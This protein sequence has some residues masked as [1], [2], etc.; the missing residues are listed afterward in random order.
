MATTTHSAPRFARAQR[1]LLA[2]AVALATS[3]ASCGGGGGGGGARLLSIA[4]TP[5]NPSIAAGTT[6]QFTATGTYSNASTK[7]LTALATWSSSDASMADVSNAAGSAGLASGLAAGSPTI[8]A[9][10]GGITGST[11]LTVSSASL[12][13]IEVTPPNPSI[14][15]GTHVRFTATGVFSDGTTQNLTTQVVWQA[16]D[17]SLA[18]FSGVAGEEGLADGVGVGAPGVTATLSGVVGSTTLSVTSAVLAAI[19]VTPIDPSIAL[20]TDLQFTATGV[21]S[22]GTTQDLT[23]L[24]DWTS[25]TGAVSVSSA[26]PANGHAHAAAVGSSTITATVSGI[27]GS[28]V[29]GVTP[30]ALV[31]IAVSPTDSS[32]ALGTHQAMTAMG[33]FTDATVQ[34]LTNQV[35]WSSSDETAV[36]VSNADGSRGIA[37][38]VARGNATI[39][40]T[41]GAV[42]GSTPMT[43]TSATLVSIDVTPAEPTIA[44]GRTQAFQATGTFTDGSTQDLTDVVTWSSSGAAVALVSNADGS[45]GL[46]ASAGAGVTTIGAALGGVSGS[47]GLTV[48]NAVLVSIETSPDA[49]DL[50][51]GFTQAFEAVGIFSDASREDLTGQVTWSSSDETIAKVSNAAGTRGVATGIGAG[52]ATITAALG[53]TS[54]SV[55]LNVTTA[56][57][58]SIDVSP[59]APTLAKGTELPLV[60][61]GTY[62]DDS[63][64]DL[65]DVVAW[66][67]S[68]E[69]A[70]IVSNAPGNQGL[71][72]AVDVGNATITASYGGFSGTA[73]VSVTAATLASI[74]V[75]PAASELPAGMTQ[76]FIAT[77]VFSDASN[78]DLSAFVTWSSSAPAIAAISNA[79]GS[80]GLAT[81]LTGGATTIAAAFAGVTGS[82]GLNVTVVTLNSIDV[83]PANPNL[84]TGY[85]LPLQATGNYSDGSSRDLTKQVLWSSAAT[86]RAT[87]SNASG[88]EG[89]VSGTG[90]GPAVISAT[91]SGVVGTTTVTVTNETLQTISVSPTSAT[92]NVD[93]TQQFRATGHFSAGTVIDITAQVRW[94]SSNRAKVSIDNSHVKGL[95][96][97]RASGGATIKAK[98]G[99]KSGTATVTVN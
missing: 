83:T 70:A 91:L 45:R 82:T 20:G 25:S 27:G 39:T 21:F 47:T 59:L 64:V 99:N 63:T 86:A 4:V 76:A 77:G 94:S 78:Q 95:A 66:S 11:S 30:A 35:V 32:I 51:A 33:T 46:A 6:R 2:T 49:Q 31:S 18:T 38:S 37:S 40:A 96:T 61:I 87:I 50:P 42:S 17:T 3:L 26:G 67:S 56:V 74:V 9:K 88:S 13:S 60:A 97:A 48:T 55:T 5:P 14:A 79:A 52:T 75:T 16:S 73:D 34:D 23:D 84:P 53:G 62:S 15:L 29:L 69:A 71:A 85:S 44:L 92:L 19:Q 24:A 7:D 90:T 72:T 58:V 8:S 1:L 68:D 10:F 80:K 89:L 93:D 28:S 36:T 12:S 57:L 54:G 98:K 41:Q 22:D 43:V 65:T 81:G